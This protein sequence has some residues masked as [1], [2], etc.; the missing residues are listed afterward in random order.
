M[1]VYVPHIG[2]K[3]NLVEIGGTLLST[4]AA[5]Q[6]GTMIGLDSV[7]VLDVCSMYTGD[8]G[9]YSQPT[10]GNIPPP[11][12]D[13]CPVVTAAPDG[14][15]YNMYEYQVHAIR[16]L[17]RFNSYFYAGHDPTTSAYYDDIYMLS[18]PS[19]TWK[20]MFSGE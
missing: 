12:T 18:L 15:S 6:N 8:G 10:S 13:P 11:R 5:D 17:T 19:F 20:K 14:P 1:L 4:F 3:G 2:L 7:N 9:W 16:M